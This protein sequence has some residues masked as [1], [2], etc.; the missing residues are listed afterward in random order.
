MSKNKASKKNQSVSKANFEAFIQTNPL[1]DLG[2]WSIEKT[3]APNLTPQQIGQEAIIQQGQKLHL[4]PQEIAGAL[5]VAKNESG[6]NPYAT[7]DNGTSFGLFQLHEQGALPS[8]WTPQMAYNPNQNASYSLQQAFKNA[9]KNMTAAEAQDWMTTHFE[10][11]ANVSGDEN[12]ASLAI[13]N[14]AYHQLSGKPE[15][16]AAQL[17]AL[18]APPSGG[19]GGMIAPQPMQSFNLGGGQSAPVQLV[20]SFG[21]SMPPQMN[22]MPSTNSNPMTLIDPSLMLQTGYTPQGVANLTTTSSIKP[23]FSIENINSLIKTAAPANQNTYYRPFAPGANGASYAGIDYGNDWTYQGGPKDIVPNYTIGAGKVVKMDPKGSWGVAPGTDQTGAALWEKLDKPINIGGRLYP[24]AYYAEGAL[25]NNLKPGEHLMGGQNIGVNMG[26]MGFAPTLGGDPSQGTLYH[27]AQQSGIDYNTFL[28]EKGLANPTPGKP[29]TPEQVAALYGHGAAGAVAS[30][31]G[32]G[33]GPLSVPPV[34]PLSLGGGQGA[35]VDSIISNG[36][37]PSQMPMQQMMP[38]QMMPPLPMA[39][40]FESSDTRSWIPG[41][42]LVSTSSVK[43]IENMIDAGYSDKQI[44]QAIVKQAKENKI[45]DIAEKE[46]DDEI[47]EFTES[48]PEDPKKYNEI[49]ESGRPG[50]NRKAS[51]SQTQG[52]DEGLGNGFSSGY[53]TGKK[54]VTDV[55][56]PITT[57]TGLVASPNPQMS[58]PDIS[59]IVGQI[60]KYITPNGQFSTAPTTGP[61]PEEV[62]NLIKTYQQGGAQAKE[63]AQMLQKFGI[64]PASLNSIK[65]S[66][67]K[68]KTNLLIEGLVKQRKQKREIEKQNFEFDR[69]YFNIVD[70]RDFIDSTDKEFRNRMAE[71]NENSFSALNGLDHQTTM[72]ILNQYLEDVS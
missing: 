46:F 30:D 7:G 41:E 29:L 32:G 28:H 12:R 49:D 45:E 52:N 58:I 50:T 37:N 24:Y 60:E 67:A 13:A 33:G 9:P 71:N 27:N 19:G 34:V 48:L 39:D 64:D 65:I 18:G 57:L 2:D 42:G 53:S 44:A 61:M 69:K 62:K 3:A 31:G 22:N 70:P 17:G 1:E 54:L 11:P 35:I 8:S 38:Q 15:L 10:R 66:A 72:L 26:E 63:I 14:Q 59:G 36:A 55:L 23:D 20:E 68:N 4:T 56:D 51:M 5:A 40:M 6:Y 47:E 25:G 43:Q 16:T 21:Q